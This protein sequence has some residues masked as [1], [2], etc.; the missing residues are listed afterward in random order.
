MVLPDEHPTL[1][2][3]EVLH[4]VLAQIIAHQGRVP[5]R[6]VEQPLDALR[7]RLSDRLCKLPAVLALDPSELPQQVA[8]DPLPSLRAK[9]CAIRPCSA[10]S[11]SDHRPTM[12][13]CSMI[14]SCTTIAL[15][16]SLHRKGSL[17]TG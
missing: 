17:R 10:F 14:P 9:R 2:I 8:S 4:Y 1:L 13:G 5:L 11:A 12:F 16:S 6:G 7:I 15:P 3:A